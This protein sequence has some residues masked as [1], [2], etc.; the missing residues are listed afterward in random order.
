MSRLPLGVLISGSGTNL[1]SIID[2]I[3]RGSLKAKIN[4][5]I[6]NKKDA[7]GLIRAEKEGIPTAYIPHSPYPSREAHEEEI[8]KEL[9]RYG[10]EVVILAGYMRL[11]TGHFVSKYPWRI[12]NIHPALLPSFKG[13]DAQKRAH[14]YGVKISGATVHFVDEEMDHGPIIIQGAIPLS[15][16]E[17]VQQ[18]SERILRIEHRIYP[19]AIQ[20]LAQGRLKIEKNRVMVEGEGPPADISDIMPCLINP[21]LEKGF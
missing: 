3:N 11:V 16:F 5:V 2:S 15:S 6:S 12:L 8:L 21:P 19:Q 10:V 14:E 17:D 4:I 18:V 1:Q 20:W 13:T 7:H 9:K